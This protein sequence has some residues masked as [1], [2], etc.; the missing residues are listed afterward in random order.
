VG[1][2]LALLL[3]AGVP[4]AQQVEAGLT[5]HASY[6]RFI[7]EDATTSWMLLAALTAEQGAWRFS[8]SVPSII[9]NSSAVSY[10]GGVPVGTGGPN[11]GTVS[12]RG[13]GERIPGRRHSGGSGAIMSAVVD[14]GF[15]EA[16]GDYRFTLG[17]PIVGVGRD[18]WRAADGGRRIGIQAFVKLPLAP[19]SS[20]VGT[21]ALDVGAGLSASVSLERSI[22][23]LDVSHWKIGDLPDLQLRDISGVTLGIGRVFGWSRQHSVMLSGSAATAAVP[24][25]EAPLSLAFGYG[26]LGE[27]GGG[28]NAGLAHGLTESTATWSAWAGWRRPLGQSRNATA[29]GP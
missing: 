23:A 11:G 12:R 15:V 7:F 16:P 10:V 25:S 22:V 3:G 8:A 1:L 2:A 18:V 19:V 29:L 26:F 28:F 4:A 6:G 20:G 17:D 13:S 21:G 27:S 9:Q 5:L 24:R 14:S